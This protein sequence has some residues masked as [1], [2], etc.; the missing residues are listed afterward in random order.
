[1]GV[2]HEADGGI[3][4]LE[5]LL[6]KKKRF[7]SHPSFRKLRGGVSA[8]NVSLRLQK[9]KRFEPGPLIFADGRRVVF[10]CHLPRWWKKLQTRTGGDRQV[11]ISADAQF[12][13]LFD[14]VDAGRRI[15]AVPN[16]ISQTEDV[17]RFLLDQFRSA[18]L[19]EQAS[20]SECRKGQLFARKLTGVFEKGH[21]VAGSI[22]PKIGFG[23]V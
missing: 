7:Y 19:L 12:T 1:M 5:L 22:R 11:V 13:S 10:G 6:G 2:T 4:I 9:W 16:N 23:R 20:W 8:R 3:E 18:L 15:R 17:L 14:Q 21:L